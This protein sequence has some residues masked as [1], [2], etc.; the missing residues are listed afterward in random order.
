MRG[1]FDFLKERSEQFFEEAQHSFQKGN[2]ELCAFD[3]EQSCQLYLKYTIG[4]LLGDFP[5]VHNLIELIDATALASNNAELTDFLQQKIKIVQSLGKA[6]FDARYY[7]T[8]F[9]VRE[10][11]EMISVVITL[12]EKLAS[13]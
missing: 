12:K 1:K 9:D 13:L 7:D 11:E 10:V 3:L 2:L 5:H 4:K 8:K 6:Y